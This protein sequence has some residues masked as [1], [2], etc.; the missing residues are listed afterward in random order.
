MNRAAGES[1]AQL[2]ILRVG[3]AGIEPATSV[4]QRRLDAFTDVHGRSRNRLFQLV[5]GHDRRPCSWVFAWVGVKIGVI[6]QGN[7]E[8]ITG[9]PR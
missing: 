1:G 7:Y 2:D 3:D 9:P 4:V 8:R 5:L 6:Y